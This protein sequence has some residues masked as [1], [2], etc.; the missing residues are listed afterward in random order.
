LKQELAEH[1]NQPSFLKATTMGQ[2]VKMQLKQNL[3]KSLSFIP[4]TSARVAD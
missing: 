1:F 4:K 2:I 3:K